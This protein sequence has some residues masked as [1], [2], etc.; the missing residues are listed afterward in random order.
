[1][2]ANSFLLSLALL[3]AAAPAAVQTPGPV[4][5]LELLG[6]EIAR[7]PS[8][9]LIKSLQSRGIDFE[10]DPDYVAALSQSGADEQT[11]EALKTAKRVE[12]S[13]PADINAATRET[14]AV[15][16]LVRGVHLNRNNF[17]A[18]DAA[19][20]FQTA[21]ASDPQSPFTHLALG[22]I[23]LLLHRTDSAASEFKQAIRLSPGLA[24]AHM[25]L[26]S[27]MNSHK[28]LKAVIEEFQQAVRLEP[29]SAIAHRQLGF[30]LRQDGQTLQAEQEQEIASK[31]AP[32]MDFVPR[33]RVGGNVMQAKAIRKVP[34]VYPRFA[35]ATRIQGTVKLEAL[36]GTD[37]SVK[38]LKH[39]SGD[40][41]LSHAA[42]DAVYQ[43][44]F[45]PTQVGGKPVEVETEIELHFKL[46]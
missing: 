19:P 41:Q 20:E 23:L 46:D 34:P 5:E 2:M 42:I 12:S 27:A 3:Q 30:Y 14:Q 43:W 1:M 40:I 39:I 6:L 21:A 31:L 4:T 9:T 33:I 7:V 25:G 44:I 28:D 32:E 24:E 11:I 17:H 29:E 37:G 45:Q 36:I 10:P 15:M 35:K 22:H 18:E 13:G 16:H 26:G 38:D 8:A